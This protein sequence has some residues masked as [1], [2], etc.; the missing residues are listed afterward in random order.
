M[1][2]EAGVKFKPVENKTAVEETF[3]DLMNWAARNAE[4]NKDAELQEIA[5]E[6][7]DLHALITTAPSFD[8]P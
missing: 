3:I 5:S 2:E 6:L 1:F 4:R 7:R 8:T